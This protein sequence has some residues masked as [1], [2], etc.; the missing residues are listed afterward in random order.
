[1]VKHTQTT[2]RRIADELFESVVLVF[3]RLIAELTELI[4]KRYRHDALVYNASQ[5]QRSS[6]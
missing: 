1:M 2:R 6:R 4:N 5:F 3:K